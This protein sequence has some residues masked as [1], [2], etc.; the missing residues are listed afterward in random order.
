MK[1]TEVTQA[2]IHGELTMTVPVQV[3][4]TVDINGSVTLRF[5]PQVQN[6]TPP[7]DRFWSPV[8]QDNSVL[9]TT[10]QGNGFS[11]IAVIQEL[12]G[13]AVKSVM[14][15]A[16][17][18]QAAPKKEEPKRKRE[19]K[20]TGS[21]QAATTADIPTS[22]GRI[23]PPAAVTAMPSAPVTAQPTPPIQPPAKDA[24]DDEALDF[25]FHGGSKPAPQEA[26]AAPATTPPAPAP[27]QAPAQVRVPSS[28]YGTG[29]PEEVLSM[30]SAL[31][32]LRFVGKYAYDEVMAEY[33][34]NDTLEEFFSKS[35][36]AYETQIG[37]WL[38][39]RCMKL[40][41]FQVPLNANMPAA[42]W[43]PAGMSK[44]VVKQLAAY[45]AQCKAEWMSTRG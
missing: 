12:E 9:R 27:E 39:T 33:E 29:L 5:P 35:V 44:V 14:A 30:T 3:S 34:T 16:L 24:A 18:P 11:G 20:A 19:S 13:T 32:V 37:N 17:E 41:V 10:T 36:E 8:S 21:P 15:S 43:K 38:Y 22:S 1:I 25:D 42:T 28:L 2:V 6:P 40:P 31:E 45:H 23:E 7:G 4:F 26:Q